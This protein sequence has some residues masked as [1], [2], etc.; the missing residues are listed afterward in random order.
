MTDINL[1]LGQ[2]V[3]AK[4]RVVDAN[5][6][7]TYENILVYNPQIA[8]VRNIIKSIKSNLSNTDYQAI[9][10]AEGELS[11]GE[12][13]SIKVERRAWRKRINE[14]EEFIAKWSD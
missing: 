7:A 2:L 9:K 4:L 14:L 11:Y 5:G 13:E 1:D 8:R 6:N 3:S 10:Y 12:F